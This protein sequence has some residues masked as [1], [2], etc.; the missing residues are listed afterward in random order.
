ME[1]IVLSIGG[2]V[3]F[4]GEEKTSFLKEFTKL[5]NK[6]NKKYKL[7]IVV[8]GGKTAR[9]YIQAGRK[10]QLD[11]KTLDQ[12]G[13]DVT[14][15]NAK[16]LT[17]LLK[18]SNQNIPSNI[19][20]ATKIKKDIVVMGGTNPGHSTDMVGAKLAEK[21]NAD[22]FIVATNVDGVYDKDPNQYEDAEKIERISAKELIDKY[23]TD[24]A[25]A[26]K[27]M[28]VDGPALKIINKAKIKTL[29]VNGNRLNQLENAVN[30]KPFDG[31]IITI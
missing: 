8:G 17:K 18:N 22:K 24:W 14:R 12:I 6:L 3:L 4:S 9:Y 13:I 29:V 21:I 25:S 31:T 2:S 11:E 10:L 15:I 27:N 20:E 30:S 26:G 1:K 16:F 28:V 7:F 23:G 5:L 19:E